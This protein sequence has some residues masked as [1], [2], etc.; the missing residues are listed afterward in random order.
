MSA[1]SLLQPWLQILGELKLGPG[2]RIA[3]GSNKLSARLAQRVLYDAKLT[4]IQADADA[5]AHR[6]QA[7]R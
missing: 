6:V 2:G 1:L 7:T 4:R 5:S 3:D